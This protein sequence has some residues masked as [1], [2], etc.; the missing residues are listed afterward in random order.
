MKRHVRLLGL[1]AIVFFAVASV[2]S[3]Q[4]PQ[5]AFVNLAKFEQ[6]SLRAQE[7]QRKFQ[8]L[9]DQKRQ[10]LETKKSE[11]MNLKDQL[12]KQGPMLKEETRN[13]KIR[14]FSVKETEFKLAEQE[15]Q[16]SLQSEYR[17]AQQ[18]LQQ[19]LVKIIS[20]IRIEKRLAY[21][22]NSAAVLSG[23]DSLDI[24][25]EVVRRY[26]AVQG[27]AT[28]HKP[29]PKAPGSAAPAKPKAR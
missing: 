12:E 3:A 25:D 1:T 9:M 29:A 2:C 10:T 28:T 26:D 7:R 16:N 23:D 14:E 24:T 21:V 19:D 18:V 5:I 11:L 15:A 17:E 6:K 20:E 27:G 22:L 4:E 8:G 13:A